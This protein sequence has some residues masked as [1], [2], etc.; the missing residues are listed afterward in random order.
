MII[1]DIDRERIFVYFYQLNYNVLLILT[2]D[3][4]FHEI[5]KF[6]SFDHYSSMVY[7]PETVYTNIEGYYRCPFPIIINNTQL[8]PKTQSLN[9]C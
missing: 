5:C 2:I 9:L 3:D 4:F 8:L 6:D 7:V 1:S